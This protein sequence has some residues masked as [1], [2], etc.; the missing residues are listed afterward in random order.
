[1]W[2]TLWK[3]ELSFVP[4]AVVIGVALAGMAT[5]IARRRIPNR[6]TGPTLLAGLIW[7]VYAGGWAGL[8]DASI[9]CVMLATPYV[10][11]FVFAGGGAGDAKLMGAIG[12][13]VGIAGGI[14]VLLGVAIA[15][16]VLA[17][18]FALAHKQLQSV[19]VNLAGTLYAMVFMV[20]RRFNLQD[21]KDVLPKASSMQTMPYGPAI[22]IG[23]CIGAA[24]VLLCRI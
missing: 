22:F 21:A 15:A 10:L 3:Q 7:A 19:L 4:W 12:A 16:I 5:D 24:G 20:S 2:M 13:W 11:L 8:L 6:L 1:M 23:V 18:I 17:I 14:I 9:A